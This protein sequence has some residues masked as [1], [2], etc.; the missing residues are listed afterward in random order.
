VK[1]GVEHGMSGRVLRATPS[2]V[3]GAKFGSS[4]ITGYHALHGVGERLAQMSPHQRVLLVRRVKTDL[5]KTKYLKNAPI[6][7]D[8][9]E[10]LR[11]IPEHELLKAHRTPTM[12]TRAVGA[13]KPDLARNTLLS[14]GL[15]TSSLLAD[16]GAIYFVAPRA[17]REATRTLS[18]PG[19]MTSHFI[20]GM[21]GKRMTAGAA[22]SRYLFGT[23]EADAHLLGE[24][25]RKE[26]KYNPKMATRV[27]HDMVDFS[28]GMP[29]SIRGRAGVAVAKRV[30]PEHW[31]SIAEVAANNPDVMRKIESQP[32]PKELARMLTAVRVR[33]KVGLPTDTKLPSFGQII[34]ALFGVGKKA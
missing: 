7:G 9:Y 31:K 28:A 5:A 12:L 1:K 25:Y 17:V 18:S 8:L 16:P 6:T 27:Y 33:D 30:N 2:V 34:G 3:V 22:T 11:R 23:F 10:A 26:L 13:G 21:G 32:K 29:E 4:T 20:R 19:T 15:L 14:R 24:A